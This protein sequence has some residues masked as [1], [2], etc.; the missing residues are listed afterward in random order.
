MLGGRKLGL[1]R[2]PKQVHG[3]GTAISGDHLIILHYSFWLGF[4]PL[5]RKRH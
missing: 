3:L 2:G 1:V 4:I 5:G